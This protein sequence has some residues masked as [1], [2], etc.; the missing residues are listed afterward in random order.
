MSQE[1][2]IGR[3]IQERR[4]VKGL[5]LQELEIASGVSQSH[6]GRAERGERFPSIDI[7]RK[8]AKPLDFGVLELFILAGYVTPEDLAEHGLKYSKLEPNVAQA[9]SEEPTEVQQAV[10]KVIDIVK[11]IA[12]H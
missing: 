2:N 6:L 10:I 12:K 7:L 5:T 1:N 3:I 4:D 9:L 8:I 11:S